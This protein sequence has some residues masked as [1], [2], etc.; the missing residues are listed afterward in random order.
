VCPYSGLHDVVVTDDVFEEFGVP[1]RVW[2]RK[3]KY[4][5]NNNGTL[6]CGSFLLETL[7]FGGLVDCLDE[8]VP[9]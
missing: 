8:V 3:M 2:I 9:R 5:S 4:N 7:V 6:R 1:R